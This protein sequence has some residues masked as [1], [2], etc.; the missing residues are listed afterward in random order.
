MPSTK[1]RLASI[2]AAAEYATCSEKT[3]R[4]RIAAGDLTGYRFGAKLIRIDLNDV[5]RLLKPI[6]SAGDAA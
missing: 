1:K 2:A 4:R 5:D 6:P 3:I